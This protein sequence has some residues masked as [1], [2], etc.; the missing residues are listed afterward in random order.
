M[1]PLC[2]SSAVRKALWPWGRIL[3]LLGDQELGAGRRRE[4]MVL[5]LLAGAEALAELVCPVVPDCIILT[6]CLRLIN[7]A[8]WPHSNKEEKKPDLQ[9]VMPY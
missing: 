7:S 6:L 1:S 2:R 3:Q 9:P 5:P 4:P 8:W